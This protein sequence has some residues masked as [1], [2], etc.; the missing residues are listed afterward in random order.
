MKDEI[1][2]I[3][4]YLNDEKDWSYYTS[5]LTPF[6]VILCEERDK[7]LDYI[8]TLQEENENLKDFNNKLQATKDRLDKYDR[9]NQMRIGKAIEYIKEEGCY[10]CMNRNQCEAQLYPGQVNTLL[11]ILQGDDNNAKD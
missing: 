1:K 3:L 10:G 11:N 8:T 4:D 6:K 7:L 2:E 5:D 9:E